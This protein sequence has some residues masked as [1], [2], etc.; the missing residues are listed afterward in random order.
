VRAFA[1]AELGPG[2]AGAGAEE[3]EEGGAGVHV[4]LA[5]LH[6]LAVHREDHRRR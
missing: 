6:P 1:A 5:E 2:E 3:L 4:P